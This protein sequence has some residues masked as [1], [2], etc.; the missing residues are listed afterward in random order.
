MQEGNLQTEVDPVVKGLSITLLNLIYAVKADIATKQRTNKAA[1][2]RIRRNL[3][4][5]EQ[6]GK[7]YRKVSNMG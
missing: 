7:L 4:A 3:I 2:A 5:I 1:Q 6:F